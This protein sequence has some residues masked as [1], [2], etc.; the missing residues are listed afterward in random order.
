VG[1]LRYR[2]FQQGLVA[3]DVVK[4][5]PSCR[6]L[7]QKPYQGAIIGYGID[8]PGDRTIAISGAE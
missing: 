2:G 7:L 3:V 4:H 5:A 1:S 6:S 8:R